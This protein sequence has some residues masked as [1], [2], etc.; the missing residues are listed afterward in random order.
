M[1]VPD[2]SILDTIDD[3]QEKLAVK[4]FIT[5]TLSAPQIEEKLHIGIKKIYRIAEKYFPRGFVKDRQLEI[6]NGKFIAAVI[7]DELPAPLTQ[8]SDPVTVIDLPAPSAEANKEASKTSSDKG[9]AIAP[10]QE[11][12]FQ[13][14]EQRRVTFEIVKEACNQLIEQDKTPSVQNIRQILKGGSFTYIS[15]YQR[16][17]LSEIGYQFQTI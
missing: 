6:N 12:N 4:A 14:S 8:A 1:N 3:L 13:P 10:V 5:T 2:I 15:K 9:S 11:Q 7:K 17:Y 16:Q